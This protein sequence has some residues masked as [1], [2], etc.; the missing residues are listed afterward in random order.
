MLGVTAGAGRTGTFGQTD[1]DKIFINGLSSEE[2]VLDLSQDPS[3]V[4]A[5]LADILLNLDENGNYTLE[6]LAKSVE[7]NEKDFAN[8]SSYDIQNS[9]SMYSGI[10][11]DIIKYA[12]DM[13]YA[14]DLFSGSTYSLEQ[15]E[16]DKENTTLA[17]F[18]RN[19]ESRIYANLSKQLVDN[20]FGTSCTGTC[21][22]SGTADVEGSTIYWV[23]DAS[24]EIITLTITDPGGNVTTM[25]VPLGDFN[26]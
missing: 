2:I 3:I 19:L 4:Q 9:N 17:R 15:I 22:T 7:S 26:F 24:T 6:E 23:K 21:P 12:D 5:Q 10:P 8:L 11:D 18:L 20:M 14:P 16:R 25:S 1:E 13:A